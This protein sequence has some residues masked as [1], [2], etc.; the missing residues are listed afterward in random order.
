MTTTA[1]LNY[2][3]TSSTQDKSQKIV[4]VG[5]ERPNTMSRKVF[6]GKVLLKH[7]HISSLRHLPHEHSFHSPCLIHPPKQKADFISIFFQ[8]RTKKKKKN[9][10][11]QSGSA[12]L[13]TKCML[14]FSV[15]VLYSLQHLF[16]KSFVFK[17]FYFLSM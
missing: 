9:G 13:G 1:V 11:N 6:T 5:Y 8:S 10:C 12:I 3:H 16:S 4:Q 14:E 15:S 7:S 2:L 17:Y